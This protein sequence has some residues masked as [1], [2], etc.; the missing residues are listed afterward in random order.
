MIVYADILFLINFLMDL[1]L[2]WAAGMLLK[3]KIKILR[4]AAGAAC[5]A[6]LYII[7]LYFPY[8]GTIGQILLTFFSIAL[9]ITAAYRPKTFTRLIKM[10]I[11]TVVLAFI[12]SGIILSLM[13]IRI[14]SS[15]YRALKG[16]FDAFSYRLLIITSI[17]FYIIIRT[18]RKQ[19]VKTA[20]DPKEYYD[21]TVYIDNRKAELRALAD[22]G[23]SLRD[24]LTGCDIIVADYLA[25]KEMLP[26]VDELQEDSVEMFKILSETDFKNRLRLIP[27]KSVGNKNGILLGIKTDKTDVY[28]PG[29]KKIEKGGVILCLFGGKLDIDGR[30]NA[31]INYEILL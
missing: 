9:S 16:I 12:A 13:M 5:G 1:T 27:F 29:S 14:Y 18:L 6:A 28:G 26:A 17:L 31:I 11:L 22:T 7:S 20:S 3:E 4:L 24:E 8:R 30:F 15:P 10:T 21:I 23:N 19:I 25:V 2:I